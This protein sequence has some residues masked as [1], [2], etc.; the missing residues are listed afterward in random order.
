MVR[1]SGSGRGVRKFLGLW[2]LIPL[3]ALLLAA[4]AGASGSKSEPLPLPLGKIPPAVPQAW[5]EW[6]LAGDGI[7]FVQSFPATLRQLPAPAGPT[8]ENAPVAYAGSILRLE[9]VAGEAG[10]GSPPLV[11]LVEGS[12]AGLV[13]KLDADG[14]EVTLTRSTGN[15]ILLPGGP[16]NVAIVG[17]L[18]LEPYPALLVDVGDLGLVVVGGTGGR[19]LA[20]YGSGP[21]AT[22]ARIYEQAALQEVEAK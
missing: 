3:G 7:E 1:R 4:A 18:P 6:R 8:L 21:A 15:T 14:V 22:L 19:N 5:S 12:Q 13:F 16:G 20:V 9:P 10:R 2:L 11:K 17:N